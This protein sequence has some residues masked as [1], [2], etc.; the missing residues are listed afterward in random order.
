MVVVVWGT[1]GAGAGRRQPGGRPPEPQ[2]AEPT[3]AR[4]AQARRRLGSPYA[5]LLRVRVS[6]WLPPVG[7]RHRR[8]RRSRTT[9]GPGCHASLSRHV[10][11]IITTRHPPGRAVRARVWGPLRLAGTSRGGVRPPSALHQRCRAR[12]PRRRMATSTGSPG[13]SRWTC[14]PSWPEW[15]RSEAGRSPLR[16]H[17]R[18]DSAHGGPRGLRGAWSRTGATRPE[19]GATAALRWQRTDRRARPRPVATAGLSYPVP[20]R[21]Q[22]RRRC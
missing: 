17:V 21:N 20:C 16:P 3:A 10:R 7:C 11:R 1:C 19:V 15:R 2:Q 18:H 6:P 8:P 9:T 14:R 4:R 22:T 5:S 12:A 13:R